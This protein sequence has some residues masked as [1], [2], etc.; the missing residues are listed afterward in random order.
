MFIHIKYVQTG[1]NS[2]HGTIWHSV[3]RWNKGRFKKNSYLRAQLAYSPGSCPSTSNPYNVTC[4]IYFKGS[5]PHE[6]YSHQYFMNQLTTNKYLTWA[7]Q[8]CFCINDARVLLALA[9]RWKGSF[10]SC[11]KW[12]WNFFNI[13]SRNLIQ[14]I[15]WSKEILY[16]LNNYLIVYD[17]NLESN[18]ELTEFTIWIRTERISNI[19]A[20]NFKGII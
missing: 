14:S 7:W 9:L 19:S 10:F 13:Y 16:F 17:I 18:Q 11:F 20:N 8:I 3:R 15:I 4:K 6:K 1:M 2:V 12:E 5:F